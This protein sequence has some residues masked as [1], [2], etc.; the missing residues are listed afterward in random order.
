MCTSQ[1]E[2]TENLEIEVKKSGDFSKNLEF[3]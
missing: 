2:S 1:P 3:H